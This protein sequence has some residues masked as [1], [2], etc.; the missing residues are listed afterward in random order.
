[1]LSFIAAPYGFKPK[2]ISIMGVVPVI[3]GLIGTIAMGP[4]IRRYN[5][6]I[7]LIILCFIGSGS[8][9]ATLPFFLET[10]SLLI[11][12]INALVDGLFLLTSKAILMEFV[13]EITYPISES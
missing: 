2:D 5:N 10:E 8:S 6:Y 12:C 9:I 13:T 1:M 7:P 3:S 11:V 4:I